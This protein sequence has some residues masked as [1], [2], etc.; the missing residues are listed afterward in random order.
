MANRRVSMR[1]IREVLRLYEECGLSNRQIARALNIS[2]PVVGQYLVN[3][4]ASGLTYEEVSK[5]S[6]D[7]VMEIFE[8]KRKRESKKYR[9]LSEK[10]PHFAKELKKKGV[11]LYLL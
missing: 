11:T 2:R 1:K 5:M 4:K 10:F 8:A 7:R 3:F 6:D 9:I